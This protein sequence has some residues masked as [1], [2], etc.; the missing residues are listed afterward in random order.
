MRSLQ[1]LGCW[2]RV[3]STA[4]SKRMTEI[5]KSEIETLADQ[6]AEVIWTSI[7]QA[8]WDKEVAL[9]WIQKIAPNHRE[10]AGALIALPVEDQKAVIRL[11]I[12]KL[13]EGFCGAAHRS[14]DDI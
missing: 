2:R 7:E 3:E 4:R 5:Q 12:Q 11:T 14:H 10:L 6:M 1:T 9:A 8:G 13:A